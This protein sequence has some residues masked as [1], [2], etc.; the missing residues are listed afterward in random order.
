MA[1]TGIPQGALSI[2]SRIASRNSV[3]QSLMHHVFRVTP[4]SRPQPWV[5]CYHLL[6]PL[7]RSRW[8]CMQVAAEI[9]AHVKDTAS[10][11]SWLF[12]VAHERCGS[13]R[14]SDRAIPW[15]MSSVFTSQKE[16]QPT[17]PGHVRISLRPTSW[18]GQGTWTS[19]HGCREADLPS[20]SYK[21]SFAAFRHRDTQ[22]G[23]TCSSRSRPQRHP[24]VRFP[25]SRVP[26]GPNVPVP[27]HTN[28][29]AFHRVRHNHISTPKPNAVRTP[30]CCNA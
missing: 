2:R 26:S 5:A 16:H 3:L 29:Q 1:A 18:A 11:P 25:C 28:E 4:S 6:H 9:G 23:Y 21:T 13:P 27:N 8:A 30:R 20:E 7:F 17:A 10:G 12:P 24:L 22:F 15:A 19:H 14:P